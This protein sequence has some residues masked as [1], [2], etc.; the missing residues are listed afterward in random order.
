[1][2]ITIAYL[3]YDFLNLYGESGNISILKNILNSLN[4]KTNIKYLSLNDELSFDDYDLVYIG[5]GTEDNQV[6][7]LKHLLKYKKDIKTYIENHKFFLATGNSIDLFGKFFEIDNNKIE[8]LNIFDYECFNQKIRFVD[9]GIFKASFCKNYILGFQNQNCIMRNNDNPLFKV[10]KGIGSYPGSDYEGIHYKNFYGTYLIGP[11]LVRNP[12]FLTYFVKELLTSI[13]PKFKMKKLD[14]KLE[15]L[16]YHEYIEKN[17][18]DI[19]V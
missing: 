13:N 15:N 16:A 17:Y 8:A 6:M 10:F 14:L 5:A 1:M 3:Y 12:H 19:L 4:V 18:K 11:I 7:A 9:E 2:K